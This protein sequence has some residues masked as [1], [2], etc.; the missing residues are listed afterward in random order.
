MI[1]YS[2]ICI[3][4]IIIFRR[5]IIVETVNIIHKSR[6]CLRELCDLT[7]AYFFSIFCPYFTTIHLL[8]KEYR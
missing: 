5:E 1:R 2:N 3:S 7:F 6:V 4:N 8:G